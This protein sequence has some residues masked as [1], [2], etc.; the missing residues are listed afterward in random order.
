M[1]LF[2]FVKASFASER[3]AKSVLSGIE[4]ELAKVWEDAFKSWSE[5]PEEDRRRLSETSYM[6]AIVLF[7]YAQS[8]ARE[9][10]A[11]RE[12]EGLVVCDAIP[13]VFSL[14]VKDCLLLRF[15][16]L[17]R[18]HV[19]KLVGA[20]ETKKRFFN[21]LPLSGLNN[22]AT[23]LTVGYRLSPAATELVA[24]EVSLQVGDDCAYFFPIG[25]NA[26][27]KRKP[28]AKTKPKPNSVVSNNPIRTKKAR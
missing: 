16:S 26:D 27:I 20:S 3:K 25:K 17:N 21:Q 12:E 23:R 24:T 1:P 28:P 15:N 4:N 10:F 8:Y 6:M 9:A 11:G 22:S 14:Y 13:G 19:V 5:L 7:G 18:N 2:E